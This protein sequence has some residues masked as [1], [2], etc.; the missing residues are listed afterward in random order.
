MSFVPLAERIRPI[1]FKD[2]YGQDH[3]L[4]KNDLI[5]KLVE[6]DQPFSVIF[7]GPQGAAKQH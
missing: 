2:V 6:N 3:L 7:W 1:E 5:T 4:G